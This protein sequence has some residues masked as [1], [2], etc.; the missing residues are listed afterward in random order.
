MGLYDQPALWKKVIE[1]TGQ[2]H[3]SYIG[4]SQGATQMLVSLIAYPEF[5]HKHMKS[6]IAIAPVVYMDD[7]N[8]YFAQELK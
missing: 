3:I 1:V 6:F 5:Y 2:Q 4:H 8:Y 7:V